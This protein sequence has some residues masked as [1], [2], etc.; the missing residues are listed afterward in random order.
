[1]SEPVLLTCRFCGSP[2]ATKV[3]PPGMARCIKEG[4]EG[5]RLAAVT[6]TEWNDRPATLAGE[7]A[8][9]GPWKISEVRTVEG[10]YMVVGGAGQEFGLIAS[11]PEKADA[12]LIVRL[13]ASGVQNDDDPRVTFSDEEAYALFLILD[14]LARVRR[15]NDQTVNYFRERVLPAYRD[16]HQANPGTARPA[17]VLPSA[18]RGRET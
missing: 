5:K 11:C 1:M 18:D 12:E 13:R 9:P 4:C 7:T 2:P 14:T 10:E 17:L 3:G 15:G 16:W 8:T 6:L